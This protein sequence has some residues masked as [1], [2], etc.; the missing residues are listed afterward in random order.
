MIHS[1]RFGD[2]YRI[3]KPCELVLYDMVIVLNYLKTKCSAKCFANLLIQVSSAGNFRDDVTEHVARQHG[4]KS[5]EIEILRP[6][7]L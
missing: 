1:F 7:A 3:S 2:S 5:E 4:N 6:S